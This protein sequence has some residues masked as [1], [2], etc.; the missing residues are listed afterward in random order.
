MRVA[1]RVL[2]WKPEGKKTFATPRRRWDVI[3]RL[4]IRNW[5]GVKWTGLI[6]LRL[7][8]GDEHL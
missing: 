1:Y 8:I 3:L 2:V 4:I 6:W 5:D 7:R